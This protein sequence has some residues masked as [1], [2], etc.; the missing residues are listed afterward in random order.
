MQQGG[1][2]GQGIK[3]NL[4]PGHVTGSAMALT[5]VFPLFSVQDNPLGAVTALAELQVFTNAVAS[6]RIDGIAMEHK[7][8]SVSNNRR[9]VRSRV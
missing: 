2:F 3:N 6:V 1:R 5:E 9:M 7:I 4:S 8:F